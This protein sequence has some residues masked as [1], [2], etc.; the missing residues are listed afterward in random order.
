MLVQL[1]IYPSQFT[2][3]N[4]IQLHSWIKL[5][6]LVPWQ[7][8]GEINSIFIHYSKKNFSFLKRSSVYNNYNLLFSEYFY[9]LGLCLQSRYPKQNVS[10]NEAVSILSWKVGRHLHKFQIHL[11]R[12]NLMSTNQVTLTVPYNH[13][14]TSEMILFGIFKATKPST[15]NTLYTNLRNVFYL[16]YST[17]DGTEAA[18]CRL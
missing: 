11:T 10:E 7:I 3:N 2:I 13:Q 8:L 12:G 17:K 4:Y 1:Q 15:A 9:V 16:Y 5:Q 6:T 14:N 18:D